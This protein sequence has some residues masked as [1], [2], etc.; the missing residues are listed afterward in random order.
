MKIL[1]TGG[2]GFIGTHLACE[3]L[4]RGDLAGREIDELI[5]AD[6]YP[7]QTEL[8]AD[9]RVRAYTGALIDQ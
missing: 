8:L 4:K 1:I 3:L 5:L 2:S 9:D 6:L 7:P